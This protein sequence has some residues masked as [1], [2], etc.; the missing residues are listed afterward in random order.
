[1]IEW[2][3]AID[4]QIV[5]LIN[6]FNSP[7]M[8]EIMWVISG[9]LTWV[10]LYL[11]LLYITFIKLGWKKTIVFFLTILLAVGCT[12]FICSGIIKDLVQR[13]RPSHNLQLIDKLHFYRY[14][15]GTFYQGGK[16]GF[17]SSHAGNFFALAWFTGWTL[18]K[19]YK[20]MLP[21]MLVIATIVS[22]SRIYLGVHYLSDIIGGFIIGTSVAYLLHK[23]VYQRLIQKPYFQ[24]EI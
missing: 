7:K 21:F 16:F 17:V 12:D 19:Y 10:P 15:N 11:F 9:K 5:L 22:L 1:M 2:L 23:F 13:Y 24:D 8:D 14:E 18:N 3:E 4:Q 20:W 6:G